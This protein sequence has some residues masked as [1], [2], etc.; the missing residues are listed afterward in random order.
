MEQN[1]FVKMVRESAKPEPETAAQ[2]PETDSPAPE[3]EPPAEVAA[4][5]KATDLPAA[6]AEKP[7]EPAG[8]KEWLADKELDISELYGQTVPGTDLTWSQLK[9]AA[10][11]V[12]DIQAAK[13]ELQ[14][15]R[16]KVL[17]SERENGEQTEWVLTQLVNKY[18]RDEVAA[19]VDGAKDGAQQTQQLE[20][21]ELIRWHPDLADPD[22]MAKARESINRITGFYGEG[23]VGM[24]RAMLRLS[25][26]ES[27]LDGLRKPQAPQKEVRTATKKTPSASG[28]RKPSRRLSSRGANKFLDKLA[29]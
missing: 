14:Q 29:Q 3:T 9:D 15:T 6:P 10:P 7:P 17:T 27:Y 1:Q 20:Q 13:L 11:D 24:A 16:D 28:K 21:A 12:A 5:P 23:R 22:N 25:Q 18:G 19:L 26:L 2:A 4:D 8:T